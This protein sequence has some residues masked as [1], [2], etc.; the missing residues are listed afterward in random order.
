MMRCQ[1]LQPH[2]R[3]GWHRRHFDSPCG[4]R[5]RRSRRPAET[6]VMSPMQSAAMTSPL[7]PLPVAPAAAGIASNFAE[8]AVEAGIAARETAL[9][10]VCFALKL[11]AMTAGLYRSKLEQI[12]ATIGLSPDATELVL[13]QWETRSRLLNEAHHLLRALIPHEQRV[14]DLIA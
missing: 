13:D 9:A 10:E 7:M 6:A 12:A 5:S 8:L 1:S 11:E 14:R 3:L 4:K 2:R